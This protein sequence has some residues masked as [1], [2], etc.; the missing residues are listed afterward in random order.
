M[1]QTLGQIPLNTLRAYGKPDQLLY[2]ADGK[3]VPI[4]AQELYDRVRQI[5]L[6]LRS[7]GLGAGDRLVILSENRP[8]WVM[9]DFA[10]LAAGAVTVPIY[11]T[12]TPEQIRYIVDD[13]EAK[14]VVC[15]TPDLQAKVDAIR[16]SLS[17]VAHFLSFEDQPA[18]GFIPFKDVVEKGRQAE[19]ADW[20]ACISCGRCVDACPMGLMPNEISIACEARNF[21]LMG[22][23]D[24]LDCFE[25]GCC[26]YVCPAKRPIVHWVKWG[27]AELAKRRAQQQ[28]QKVG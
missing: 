21:D 11:P 25:C 26:T 7:L 9:T 6:G 1:I 17:R 27:K 19:A 5:S 2:K 24:I 3:Y 23:V 16:P 14:I 10:V 8:D 18:G 28:K 20:R 22:A 13:S 15:S 12:L 4:S